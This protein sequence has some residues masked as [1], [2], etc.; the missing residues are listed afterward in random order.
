L[1]RGCND[2]VRDSQRSIL[3]LRQVVKR[4]VAAFSHIHMAAAIDGTEISEQ[5]KTA[6]KSRLAMLNDV[7]QPSRLKAVM[8]AIGLELG[9]DEDAA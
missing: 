7:D 6:L 9:G 8:K 5:A 2:D 4:G 3:A 1:R